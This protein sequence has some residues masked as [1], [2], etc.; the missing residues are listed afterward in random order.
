MSK[1]SKASA[2]AVFISWEDFKKEQA[3][4]DAW[5]KKH[6]VLWQLQLIPRRILWAFET[7]FKDWPRTMRH[8]LQR[9]KQGYSDMDVW[10]FNSYLCT[11]IINGLTQLKKEA[12][13]YP[14]C[15]KD[16]IEW[17]TILDHIIFTFTI[18][19]KIIDCD[20]VFESM[21]TPA[22]RTHY[23]SNCEILTPL[24]EQQY[25]HGWDLFR[26]HFKDLWD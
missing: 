14:N 11:A 22:L 21:I 15:V 23:E 4:R 10:T 3:V 1:K 8:S 18:E 25:N 6:P 17:M 7:V 20:A 2:N 12:H 19:K 13:G 16:P 5:R 26:K 24:I 9:F